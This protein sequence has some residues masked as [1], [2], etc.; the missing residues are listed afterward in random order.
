[1]SIFFIKTKSH[2]PW[3]NLALEEY[4]AGLIG[5]GDV[6]LY[7]WRN[8]RTVVIGRNQNA[9][10]ECRCALLE[11]EGGRLSRRKT[12]G[13]AVYQDLGNLC[14]TFLASPEVYDQTKQFSVIALACRLL[15]IETILSGRNDILTADGLKFSGNAFSHTAACSIHHGTLMVDVDTERMKRYLTPSEDKLK[16]K[17]IRSVQSRVVNLRALKPELTMAELEE[18][19][20]E[21]FRRIYRCGSEDTGP[22]P[23]SS[24]ILSEDDLDQARIRE[25]SEQYASWEWRYG[26]S[27]DCEETWRTRF[28]WGGVEVWFSLHK[29]RIERIRIYS[30]ALDPKL[31]GRLEKLLTGRKA[32]PAIPA[33]K[34]ARNLMGTP[35]MRGLTPQQQ[36]QH[37]DVIRALLEEIGG[38]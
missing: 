30:D 6:M 18:T 36:S 17:G 20:Q 32:D 13:G 14:F 23:V 37:E 16:A 19:L 10:R 7:L 34:Q 3:H 8:D 5:P 35:E 38:A 11:A 25:L 28:D 15:G 4:L 33:E 22:P 31:P 12:G 26:K 27:P 9:L 2:D 1:M 29:L 21:A 24:V